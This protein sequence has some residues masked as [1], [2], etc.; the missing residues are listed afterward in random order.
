M[1]AGG[2]FDNYSKGVFN[3][4][5]N[6]GTNHMVAIVGWDNATKSWIVRNSWGTSFGEAGYFR[7]VWTDKRGNKCQ[8]LGE[9]AA[10]LQTVSYK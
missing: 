4:C 5:Y 10:V 3:S 8:S 1:Y 9:Q 2:Y 6:G 7:I